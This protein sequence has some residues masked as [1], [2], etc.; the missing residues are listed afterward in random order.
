M[1]WFDDVQVEEL[2]NFDF[3][4]DEEVFEVLNKE[5]KNFNDYLNSNYDYWLTMNS[6]TVLAEMKELREIWRKQSFSLSNEQQAQY[7][8]LLELR[9][10]RVSELYENDMVYKYTATK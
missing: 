10:Q 5:E 2:C 4:E 3:I 7:N 1:D 9:R 6:A 8:K